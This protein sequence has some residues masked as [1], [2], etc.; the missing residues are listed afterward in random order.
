MKTQAS[1][2]FF[3]GNL[4]MFD[5]SGQN[6]GEFTTARDGSLLLSFHD[7]DAQSMSFLNQ[8]ENGLQTESDL[9]D[10]AWNEWQSICLRK[11]VIRQYL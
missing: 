9:R 4:R 2:K 7:G 6:D 5:G 11:R 1:S 8:R 10:L 3:T